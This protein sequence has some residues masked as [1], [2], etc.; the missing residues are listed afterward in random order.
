MI[1]GKV[2]TEKRSF[3]LICV[4]LLAFLV[5][6]GPE[7]PYVRAGK[8]EDKGRFEE[9]MEIY[10]GI[11]EEE[12]SEKI[13]LAIANLFFKM[14]DDQTGFGVL[15]EG[16][17]ELEEEPKLL[18]ELL[19]SKLEN[20]EDR[21]RILRARFE[22]FPDKTMFIRILE[23][24][25]D[26][27]MV[28][29]FYNFYNSKPEFRD[30]DVLNVIMDTIDYDYDKY[31][32]LTPEI[33]DMEPRADYD[34]DFIARVLNF[35]SS[36][37][38]QDTMEFIDG[39]AHVNNSSD[40]VKAYLALVESGRFS[41]IGS[42][43]IG[44]AEGRDV[45]YVLADGELLALNLEDYKL[46]DRWSVDFGDGFTLVLNV[47]P[48]TG[49]QKNEEIFYSVFDDSMFLYEKGSLRFLSGKFERL[50]ID[51]LPSHDVSFVGPKAYLTIDEME[52]L[53]I[54]DYEYERLDNETID[55]NS[56]MI[57]VDYRVKDSRAIYDRTLDGYV[58]KESLDL[59]DIDKNRYIGTLNLYKGYSKGQI[60]LLDSR[61][62]QADGQEIEFEEVYR[63]LDSIEEDY[64]R[65]L[66]EKFEEFVSYMRKLKSGNRGEAKKILGGNP[67][68]YREWAWHS[69]DSERY[70]NGIVIAFDPFLE[71]PDESPV[72]SV[73]LDEDYNTL[74]GENGTL[75]YG[76]INRVFRNWEFVED[77]ETSVD[78]S[79]GHYFRG[80]DAFSIYNKSLA[81]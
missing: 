25:R 53:Y 7:D 48:F 67:V 45:L 3:L 29:D 19:F 14:G 27:G 5:S 55:D 54:F 30:G 4:L 44:Q 2:K 38:Y 1:L 20:K 66:D 61:F 75:T 59:K 41:Y 64:Y 49:D 23:I 74:L 79:R 47:V 8:L 11:Y 63:T 57:E 68:V 26:S 46:L 56:N 35:R 28:D 16:Y 22:K 69:S 43:A 71:D 42:M 70:D 31:S 50:I 81:Y 58:L 12:K 60:K 34:S 62:T 72:Y 18:E 51:D 33:L 24:Y 32:N 13:Y 36:N 40:L 6:C 39:L 80:E 21:I 15:E 37:G 65:A 9:A 17:T 78:Y 77:D 73:I 76:Y 10:D 52:R